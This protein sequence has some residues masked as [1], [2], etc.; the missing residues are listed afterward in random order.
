MI[1]KILNFMQQAGQ[2]AKANQYAID[3]NEEQRLKE[4]EISSI[5]TKTDF[6]VSRLFSD[7]I[8]TNFQHLNYLIVDEET[9]A[10]LPGDPFELINNTEY[11]FVIDPIDGTL[12]FAL[13]ISDYGISVG[14]LK[15]GKPYLGCV[16]APGINELA[17]FDGQKVYWLE[18][19]FSKDERKTVLNPREITSK[20]F[21]LECP[22]FFKMND[23]FDIK[24]IVPVNFYSAVLQLLY[25]ITG[26]AR[27][28]YF[29]GRLWDMAGAW[30][31]L[32]YLGFEFVNYN[33]AEILNDVLKDDFSPVLKTKTGYIVCKPEDFEFLKSIA[34]LK[35]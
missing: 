34:D 31:I 27:A 2:I 13:K 35:D 32:K 14:V 33:N 20:A 8:K 26:R 17:Y 28:Y 1:S 3:L 25:V 19:A 4:A 30:P 12:P 6:E 9:I 23:S 22:W 7:F 5:V 18:K 11:T 21:L 29:G 24:K 16:Y 15:Y 10:D